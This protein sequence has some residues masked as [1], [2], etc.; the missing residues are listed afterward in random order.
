ML[1]RAT[2]TENGKYISCASI[3]AGLTKLIV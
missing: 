2:K 1:E 3:E